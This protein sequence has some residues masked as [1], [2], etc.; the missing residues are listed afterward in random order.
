MSLIRFPGDP[1]IQNTANMDPAKKRAIEE[2]IKKFRGEEG[3]RAAL[4]PVLEEFAQQDVT[5]ICGQKSTLELV[6][7]AI[8]RELAQDQLAAIDR[9]I[10]IV[11]KTAEALGINLDMPAVEAEVQSTIT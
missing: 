10:V 7:D 2:L 4:L 5:V 1:S 3:E 9:R 6:E 8:R 11:E